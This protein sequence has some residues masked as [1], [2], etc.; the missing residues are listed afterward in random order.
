ML[1]IRGCSHDGATRIYIHQCD[2]SRTIMDRHHE[3]YF[4]WSSQSR[5]HSLYMANC[6]RGETKLPKRHEMH[7]RRTCPNMCCFL[8][9]CSTRVLIPFLLLLCF[10]VLHHHS[11]SRFYYRT[12]Q[13]PD[14]SPVSR[15]TDQGPRA[16]VL[17][18]V[19]IGAGGPLEQEDQKDLDDW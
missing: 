17:G 12:F 9:A 16:Q 18:K 2:E 8:F 7:C 11:Q 5:C 4:G 3:Y 10:F 15:K 6:V 14:V 1:T 19:M 13:A